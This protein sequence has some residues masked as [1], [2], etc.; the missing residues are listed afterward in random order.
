[1]EDNPSIGGYNILRKVL[2][3]IC[4]QPFVIALV[5]CGGG[6]TG[7]A[8]SLMPVWS[9]DGRRIAFQ[10]DRDGSWE[11]YVMDADGINR[12]HLLKLRQPTI[13]I[14]VFSRFQFILQKFLLFWVLEFCIDHDVFSFRFLSRHDHAN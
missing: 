14:P 12:P 1:M 2:L 8:L 5:L 9:P 6:G 13:P 4:F 7:P 10:S 11:I 3:S